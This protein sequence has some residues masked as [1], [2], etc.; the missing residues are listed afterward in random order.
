MAGILREHSL[1]LALLAVVQY[2][3]EIMA[4][5]NIWCE[6]Q[7]SGSAF[8]FWCVERTRSKIVWPN[9]GNQHF[10]KRV[11]NGLERKLNSSK[12]AIYSIQPRRA[13]SCN[14]LKIKDIAQGKYSHATRSTELVFTQYEIGIWFRC[15]KAS[16]FR[17]FNLIE[18][19]CLRH[20][21]WLGFFLLRG[22]SLRTNAV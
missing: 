14:F 15:E 19:P 21:S 8:H 20:V 18:Q 11:I 9:L 13:Y 3:S 2:V 1:V 4:L 22:H 6:T 5:S 12:K 10:I 17:I 7:Y 16:N